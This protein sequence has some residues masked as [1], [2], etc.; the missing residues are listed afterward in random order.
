MS[1]EVNRKLPAKNTTVQ[2]LT[3]YA[4]HERH[5]AQRCRRTDDVLMAFNANSWLYCTVEKNGNSLKITQSINCYYLAQTYFN[6]II[7]RQRVSVVIWFLSHCCMQTRQM[8][9]TIAAVVIH[10][11]YFSFLCRKQE[12][13][14]HNSSINDINDLCTWT[15]LFIRNTDSNKKRQKLQQDKHQSIKKLCDS[16]TIFHKTAARGGMIINIK[17]FNAI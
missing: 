5:N 6:R 1:D 16:E 17:P 2:L 14:E 12:L 4:D 9:R 7:H 13:N 3:L 15:V 10:V 11:H 8:W